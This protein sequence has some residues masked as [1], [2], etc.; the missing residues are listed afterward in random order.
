MKM[1]LKSLLFGAHAFWL[2]PWFVAIA[3]AK[4]YGIPWDPRL[5]IAFIVHDWGYWNKAEMDSPDGEMH[6]LL[7]G[8]IMNFLFDK[9]A[10]GHLCLDTDSNHFCSQCDKW[11]MLSVFH[12]RYVAKTINHP[13]SKLCAADKLAVS[14]TPIWIYVPMAMATGEIW[15]YMKSSESRTYNPWQ[16]FRLLKIY[17]R[18]QAYKIINE[19][20]DFV[21]NDRKE[22]N[23]VSI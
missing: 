16:W 21:V 23:D 5:W 12:S 6:P 18:Q 17:M 19:G 9:Q 11:W 2:H 10:P 15:E 20:N 8:R 4:L 1:G 3:W 14:L 22:M 7:G 13:V